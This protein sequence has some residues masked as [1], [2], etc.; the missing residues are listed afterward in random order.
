MYAVPFYILNH[1]AQTYQL[2]GAQLQIGVNNGAYLDE[3]MTKASTN[4][5][6]PQWPLFQQ[7]P[8]GAFVLQ[9]TSIAPGIDFL[10]ASAGGIPG[11]YE[12]MTIYVLP[13][14]GEDCQV[15]SFWGAFPKGIWLRDDLDNDHFC[16]LSPSVPLP[17]SEEI[18][19]PNPF[20]SGTIYKVPPMGECIGSVNYGIPD[21]T[22]EMEILNPPPAATYSTTTFVNG[23]YMQEINQIAHIGKDFRVRPVYNDAFLCGVTLHD[24]ALIENHLLGL[25]SFQHH[26]QLIAADVNESNSVSVSDIVAIRKVMLSGENSDNL[27][28]WRFIPDHLYNPVPSAFPATYNEYRDVLNLTSPVTGQSF[29]GIKMG[30]VDG[31]CTNCADNPAYYLIDPQGETHEGVTRASEL[32]LHAVFT[33]GP[34]GNTILEVVS[35]YPQYLG[36]ILLLDFSLEQ[37]RFDQPEFA[38]AVYSPLPDEGEGVVV[39]DAIRYGYINS[40]HATS[41][42]EAGMVLL[43]MELG[44]RLPERP[45]ILMNGE[46]WR[47]AQIV[48]GRVQPIRIEAIANGSLV[49]EPDLAVWP[50]PAR[51]QAF[52]RSNK[53]EPYRLLDIYGRIVGQGQLQPG[54]TA[55]PLDGL[56]NGLYLL[57]TAETTHRLRVVR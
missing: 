25:Q 14:P 4:I 26:W 29:I 51:D 12:A 50:N 48:D 2:S 53:A 30:D 44:A 49:S 52:V 17:V 22:V 57:Q 40:A 47:N 23:S 15:L 41:T 11:V 21:V 32:I 24:L 3:A 56:G 19:L 36:S 28:S 39:N 20:I 6:N 43:R 1:N 37:F 9:Q 54:L 7:G 33:K 13:T 27:K 5:P 16:E 8:N 42:L 45:A 10:P 31:S 34:D 55:L 18:C 35:P 46:S 38:M